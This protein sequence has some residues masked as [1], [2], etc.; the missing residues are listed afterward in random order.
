MALSYAS[1]EVNF[2]DQF[3]K[4][5]LAIFSFCQNG[6]FE[7]MHEIQKKIYQIRVPPHWTY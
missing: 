7:P 3:K 5:I 2:M 4:A 6:T 1:K